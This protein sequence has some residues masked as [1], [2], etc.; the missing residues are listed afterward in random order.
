MTELC[1]DFDELRGIDTP[2][3]D[4]AA[5]ARDAGV[6]LV[7]L[8]IAGGRP[9]PD[10]FVRS[11]PL[12]PREAVTVLR[13][14]GLEVSLARTGLFLCPAEGSD[15]PDEVSPP[16]QRSALSAEDH[17]AMLD[18][19]IEAATAVG[20]GA[21]GCHAFWRAHGEAFPRHA[22]EILAEAAERTRRAGMR[23]VLENDHRTRAGTG[24]ELA[25][26]LDAVGAED[27]HAGYDVAEAGRLGA[28]S[29]ADLGAILPRLVHLRI[30]SQVVDVRVGWTGGQ[31]RQSFGLWLQEDVPVAGTLD[32]G[33]TRIAVEQ[34]RNWLLPSA[35]V[36]VDYA[37][38]FGGPS[39]FAGVVSVTGDYVVW[40]MGAEERRRNV[41]AAVTDMAQLAE[42]AR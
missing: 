29:D 30:R 39:G 1:V 28:L 16:S 2:A 31:D 12:D 4:A 35:T 25:A 9:V 22:A 27:L 24:R 37:R 23:L 40:G 42:A 41:L 38:W 14:H 7:E 33:G 34:A 8:R 21:I 5:I 32:W 15:E 19:V 3:A 18:G 20:A 10:P 26:V 11:E 17:L 6:R 13:S 36:G